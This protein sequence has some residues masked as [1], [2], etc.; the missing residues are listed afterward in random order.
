MA[1]RCYNLY[2]IRKRMSMSKII[3]APEVGC[4]LFSYAFLFYLLHFH[5]TTLVFMVLWFGNEYE[6]EEVPD[7]DWK[8]IT[9]N[10]KPIHEKT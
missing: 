1:L 6:S 7:K 5:N 3:G 10:L 2:V 9:Y 8:L 4:L